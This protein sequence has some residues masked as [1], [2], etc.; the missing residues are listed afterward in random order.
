MA[1]AAFR[2]EI[3]FP[4]SGI[5]DQNIEV[6]I[7]LIERGREPIQ[8]IFGLRDIAAMDKGLE[9]PIDRRLG[10]ASSL[11][12]SLQREWLILCLQQFQDVQGL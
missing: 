10:N 5:A 11:V 3:R 6:L 12:K 4:F 2:I 9:D 8:A 7:S 1:A